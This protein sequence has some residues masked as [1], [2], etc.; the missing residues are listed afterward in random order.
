MLGKVNP[1][2]MII[3]SIIMFFMILTGCLFISYMSGCNFER[4][5]STGEC[6]VISTFVSTVATAFASIILF[7]HPE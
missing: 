4:N 3:T 2:I 7:V 1:H 5:S 6:F